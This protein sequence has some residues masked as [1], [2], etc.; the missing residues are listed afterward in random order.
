MNG[1]EALSISVPFTFSL[2]LYLPHCCLERWMLVNLSPAVV[3]VVFFILHSLVDVISFECKM[4]GLVRLCHSLTRSSCPVSIVVTVACLPP[5][6][7]KLALFSPESRLRAAFLP[8]SK[9]RLS[10]LSSNRFRET[11]NRPSSSPRW[12]KIVEWYSRMSSYRWPRAIQMTLH[13]FSAFVFSIFSFFLY[14]F[15]SVFL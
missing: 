10:P 15:Y 9:K 12:N 7:Q 4:P 5:Q 1:T 2:S 3:L 13:H 6:P 8:D 14:L 11:N